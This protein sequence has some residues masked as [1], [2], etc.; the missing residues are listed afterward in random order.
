M[1]STTTENKLLRVQ[2]LSGKQD[3]VFDSSNTKMH[4]G[5]ELTH[6]F[7]KEL[8]IFFS[9]PPPN[10]KLC[11]F[12]CMVDLLGMAPVMCYNHWWS[13]WVII[14]HHNG[15]NN[16]NLCLSCFSFTFSQ[17]CLWIMPSRHLPYPDR[18]CCGQILLGHN[19]FRER[20]IISSAE[21]PQTEKV[22]LHWKSPYGFPPLSSYRQKMPVRL[23][24]LFFGSQLPWIYMWFITFK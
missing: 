24:S 11:F 15:S 9:P 18:A 10:S 6:L 1:L 2:F 13:P 16:T 20:L 7:L 5:C 23:S 12:L 3:S 19:R 8:G 14:S 21:I 4:R 22:K 17:S